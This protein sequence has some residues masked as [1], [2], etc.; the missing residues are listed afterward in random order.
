MLNIKKYLYMAILGIML[1][2]CDMISE[3]VSA[4]STAQKSIP[5][6]TNSTVGKRTLSAEVQATNWYIRLVAEDAAK[7]LL[8]SDA[9]LGVLEETDA[10]SKHTLS[11][12]PPMG[13]NYL[14]IVFRNPTGMTAGDYKTYFQPW[15]DNSEYRWRF[16]VRTDQVNDQIALTWRGV[17]VLSPYM[18]DQN[19]QRYTERRSMTNPIVHRMRLVDVQTGNT[20]FA[21][22]EG[23]AKV[24]YFNMNGQSERTFEWVMVAKSDPILKEE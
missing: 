22:S 4:S 23:K 2:G 16:T 15:V 10:T 9:Q 3:G 11:A 17:Y 6:Q 14:D 5:L 24:Y 1:T 19:R 21:F 18:D 7:G 20:V 8:S 13:S 12:F